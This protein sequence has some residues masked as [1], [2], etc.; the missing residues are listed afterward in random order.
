V[1]FEMNTPVRAIRFDPW[2]PVERTAPT[3]THDWY[4]DESGRFSSG[5]WASEPGR[6]EVTYE[7]DE[8]CVLIAGIV[9]LIDATGHVE[10]YH[11]G[12]TFLIPSGFVGTWETVEPVR[13][14]FAL[15]KPPAV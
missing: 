1:A 4:T 5:F 3:T 9:R 15:H 13:K 10:T 14:F 6:W 7:E 11:A 12:E 2:A 8:L